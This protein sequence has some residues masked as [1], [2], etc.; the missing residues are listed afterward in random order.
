MNLAL[1]NLIQTCSI[2]SAIIERFQGPDVFESYPGQGDELISSFKMSN[3]NCVALISLE[4][5]LVL[6]IRLVCAMH[7]TRHLSQLQVDLM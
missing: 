2:D 4:V 3:T 7:L 6:F 5:L 1:S